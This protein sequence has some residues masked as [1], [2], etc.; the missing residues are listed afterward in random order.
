MG[1]RRTCLIPANLHKRVDFE[2]EITFGW[3]LPNH[4]MGDWGH[5]HWEEEL[6]Q[7]LDIDPDEVAFPI[8]QT[9]LQL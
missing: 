6:D 4:C 5:E 8:G 1:Q 2:K 7:A 3:P 9:D